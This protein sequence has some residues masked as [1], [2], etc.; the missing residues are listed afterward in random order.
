MWRRMMAGSLVGLTLATISAGAADAKPNRVSFQGISVVVPP[1]GTVSKGSPRLYLFKKS[2]W[3]DENCRLLESEHAGIQLDIADADAGTGAVVRPATFD[4][5][6][7][8]G[9]TSGAADQPCGSRS[10]SVHF[11]EDDETV[12]DTYVDFG[13]KVSPSSKREAYRI[14][15]SIRGTS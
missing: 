12:V 15:N 3:I 1:D 8:T 11:Q 2:R 5:T 7:G 10:Q 13:S 9:I 14:L 6:T 4:E